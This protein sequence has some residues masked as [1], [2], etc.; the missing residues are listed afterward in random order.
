MRLYQQQQYLKGQ[1][2]LFT[3]LFAENDR[4]DAGNIKLFVGVELPPIFCLFIF[5]KPFYI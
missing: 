1:I 5:S 4:Y 3:Q 2:R